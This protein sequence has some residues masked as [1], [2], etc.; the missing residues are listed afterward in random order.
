MKNLLA[1]IPSI[2]TVTNVVNL[3]ILVANGVKSVIDIFRRKKK[4]AEKSESVEK[5]NI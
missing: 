2:D 4:S 5:E 3:V 1:K